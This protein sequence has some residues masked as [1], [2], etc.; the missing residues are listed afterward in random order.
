MQN[1]HLQFETHAP[2]STDHQI[3][4]LYMIQGP[5]ERQRCMLAKHESLLSP[6]QML[7]AV[8]LQRQPLG[9]TDHSK[10]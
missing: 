7:L 3:L 5:W 6:A 2:W 1:T 9:L 4:A 10:S 8:L